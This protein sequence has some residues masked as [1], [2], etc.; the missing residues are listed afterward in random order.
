[1]SEQLLRQYLKTKYLGRKIYWFNSI[2]STNLKAK[3]LANNGAAHGTIVIADEQTAGR[4]RMGRSWYSESGKNLTF[5]I[6]LNPQMNQHY[7]GALSL[8]AGL[9]VTQA[10]QQ[11]LQVSP[12]CKWPNDILID[13][14]KICG[15]LSESIFKD[16]DLKAV[17][18]GI[19]LNVNQTIFPGDL[20]RTATS[21]AL[22]SGREFNRFEVLAKVLQRLET[23]YKIIQKGLLENILEKWKRF[24]PMFEKE[25]LVS[26]NENNI[27]GIAVG[28]DLDGGLILQTENGKKKIIAGE[29]TLCC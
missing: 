17:I 7:I 23:N 18:I 2:D 26:Q 28:L 5:S 6:I 12:K 11:F 14:K 21:L 19:G 16:K 13:N 4:G 1:M 27:R 25:T 9:S 20:N 29:V 24:S 8:Y 15:I 3:E 10:L 22:A